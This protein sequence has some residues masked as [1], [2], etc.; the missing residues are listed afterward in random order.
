MNKRRRGRR[1][2]VKR[3]KGKKYMKVGKRREKER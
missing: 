2:D 1:I 3:M